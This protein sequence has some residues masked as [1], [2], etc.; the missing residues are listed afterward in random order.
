MESLSE[1]LSGSS[2]GE[3]QAY[4]CY[5]A[6]SCY[7]TF[8]TNENRLSDST[9][10]TSESSDD[11]QYRDWNEEWQAI[12]E[13]PE[14][15]TKYK[16]LRELV[17]DFEYVSKH[18][19]KI[20]VHEIFKNEESRIIKSIS[21]AG[22]AG[23]K[24]FMVEGI[25]FKFVEDVEISPGKWLYG[26]SKSAYHLAGKAA[27][28]EIRGLTTIYQLIS[29]LNI[30]LCI[31]L[32][33]LIGYRGFRV[34]AVSKLPINDQTLIY[35]SNNGGLTVHSDEYLHLQMGIIAKELNL[36]EHQVN[37]K[38]I[39]GPGDI[40]GHLG[41]DGRYYLLDFA[42]LAPPEYPLFK[43]NSI[44]YALLR[45]E[46]VRLNNVPLSSDMFTLWQSKDPVNM[47][48]NNDGLSITYKLR[49]EAIPIF[50]EK[51]DGTDIENITNLIHNHGINCRHL[52]NI[53][54]QLKCDVTR[55]C[56]ATEMV[57]RHIKDILLGRQRE[58]SK[59][60]S[61]ASQRAY[62]Y[63]IVNYFNDIFKSYTGF[64]KFWN[65]KVKKKLVKK[66][67]CFD[68]EPCLS[69]EE[70]NNEYNFIESIHLRNCIVRIRELTGIKFTDNY[71]SRVPDHKM[72]KNIYLV[73]GD[74]Y[75]AIPKISNADI[76][77]PPNYYQD[78]ELVEVSNICLK[79][80]ELYP[81][82]GATFKSENYERLNKELKQIRKSLNRINFI[83]YYI[84]LIPYLNVLANL[85]QK[86]T[87]EGNVYDFNRC[88][89][90]IVLSVEDVIPES[91]V[92][93][94]C[95]N[96]KAFIK[97]HER[98]LES[99]ELYLSRA[100]QSQVFRD[101]IIE[102]LLKKYERNIYAQ[103]SIL[104]PPFCLIQA[105]ILLEF[106]EED[107]IKY[108]IHHMVAQ[109]LCIYSSIKYSSYD[110]N[111][112][113]IFE[114]FGIKGKNIEEVAVE[115]YGIIRYHTMEAQKYNDNI[116]K[117]LKHR[118]SE[119]VSNLIVASLDKDHSNVYSFDCNSDVVDI[120]AFVMAEQG[121]FINT[122]VIEELHI[123]QKSAF[124]I[125]SNT[126]ISQHVVDL[127]IKR[128]FDIEQFEG[129]NNLQ[130]LTICGFRKNTSELL[131]RGIEC[132]NLK[133]LVFKEDISHPMA[134]RLFSIIGNNL[135]ELEVIITEE[136]YIGMLCPNLVK[137]TLSFRT[138]NP[139]AI[140]TLSDNCNKLKYLSLKNK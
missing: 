112:K 86:L 74:I 115:V 123:S 88:N 65:L 128:A 78:M 19:A 107:D 100:F 72:Q 93:P 13:L 51:Y 61:S 96:M 117:A 5:T 39:Y 36:R 42:R 62:I 109:E 83:F 20:L 23:G 135:N 68:K 81:V 44:L 89:S 11:I 32:M 9:S 21:G 17:N 7:D 52:G 97:M 87:T 84:D 126:R 70:L 10:S 85:L 27:K 122:P 60:T 76:E 71:I 127:E 64:S 134:H 59:T 25:F 12:L 41:L 24:K 113:E 63:D 2:D 28:H 14:T 30:P 98:D 50:L 137:L 49:D 131:L 94:N 102:H 66:F 69:Q 54:Q 121:C 46:I 114:L 58:L 33:S 108:K 92:D 138:L 111:V 67:L 132:L 124:D 82:V 57:A 101:S 80:S 6:Y 136:I 91:S 119:S 133:A 103:K 130:S 45:L 43:S 120:L 118:F 35:G 29:K 53:Y 18:Y 47:D 3:Y 125:F 95:L 56:I 16:V 73:K 79:L 37:N 75:E 106:I 15:I 55:R 38:N 140:R 8:S 34:I 40:E 1:T 22:V 104:Q 48:L 77:E 105:I 110:A 139:I 26:G 31:P 129:W 90:K 4:G 116:I 99:T